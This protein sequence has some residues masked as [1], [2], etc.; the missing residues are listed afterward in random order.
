MACTCGGPSLRSSS[1]RS[2][3]VGAEP[4]TSIPNPRSRDGTWVTDMPGILRADTIARLNSTIGEFDRTNGGEMA[5][6]VIGSLDG[7][8]IEEAA[9]QAVRA[10]GHR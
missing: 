5:V 8:S 4:L 1:C 6:V 2:R 3:T 7:L 10:W 9:G